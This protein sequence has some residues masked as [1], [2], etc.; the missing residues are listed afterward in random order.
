MRIAVLDDYLKVAPSMAKWDGLNAEVSFFSEYIQPTEMAQTLESFD[1][2]VAMRERSAFP[3]TLI[4]AL[5]NLRLIVTTGMR[6]SSIDMAA[7]RKQGID[8]CGA[9]GDPRSTGATAELAWSVLLGLFKQIP[10]EAATM[11]KGLWQT[12]MPP[13]LEAKRLGLVGAGHLG[14]C[15]GRVGLA[16]GMEVVAWS[17][18]LT[19]ERA[20]KA[21]VK[22]VTQQELFATS[23]AI[24]VHMVL[25]ERSRGIVDAASLQSMKPTAYFINTSRA[26]LVDQAALQRLLTE[27]KIAGAGIDVYDAEPLAVADAWRT[28]PRTL[29]TPHL[30]YVTPENFAVFYSNVVADIQAWAASAPIRVLN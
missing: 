9:P 7:C 18:N 12:T 8:V 2:I 4:Q 21:G 28:T 20:A 6:N 27:G 3:A 11:Q 14:Q 5:P 24:S 22:L 25:S 26:G 15:V 23:D 17:P 19:E 10:T 13:T 29:L 30:G 16:F 1:V